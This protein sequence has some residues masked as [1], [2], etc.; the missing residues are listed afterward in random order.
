MYFVLNIILL[1]LGDVLSLKTILDFL[2]T[3]SSVCSA[4]LPVLQGM[5]QE[6]S[7]VHFMLSGGASAS[8]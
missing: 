7:L 2:S 8:H 4:L 6:S 3:H 1:P 5:A